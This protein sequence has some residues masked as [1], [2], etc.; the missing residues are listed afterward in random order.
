[1]TDQVGKTEYRPLD[2]KGCE[3][4]VLKH[5]YSRR[6]PSAITLVY[7]LVGYA[8]RRTAY[9]CVVF[10]HATGR[11]EDV[12]LW[13][14]TRL[15]RLPDYEGSLTKL[16]GKALGH[17][18]KERLVNLVVSFAD[19]EEGHHGG[20]YQ[21]CSWIYDGM[22]DERLDGFNINGVFTPARTCNAQ[23]GTSSEEG[24][25]KKLKGAEVVPHYDRGKHRYW[26]A[27]SKEGMQL[28]LSLGFRSRPYPKPMLSGETQTNCEVDPQ[29]RKGQV[30]LPAY[31][32]ASNVAKQALDLG[33]TLAQEEGP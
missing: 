11:H 30:V 15:V 24:L 31:R 33:D 26:K 29:L 1:M 16:V 12:P 9:A 2:V 14:L 32:G 22:A 19:M 23:Y 4:L 3:E 13:E 18:R 7:G 28:A 17:V 25:R 6:M 21:A 10:S 8:P 20:I 27:L 5:H